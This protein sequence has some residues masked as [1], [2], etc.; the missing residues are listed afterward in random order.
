MKKELSPMEKTLAFSALK[1]R[2]FIMAQ[3]GAIMILLTT[4]APFYAAHAIPAIIIT[5]I[6]IL[7]DKWGGAQIIHRRIMIITVLVLCF[8]IGVN[9]TMQ[10]FP[11]P[12]EVTEVRFPPVTVTPKI[13]LTMGFVGHVIAL[14]GAVETLSGLKL[15]KD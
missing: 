5:I 9:T 8:W 4:T 3:S 12:P 13:T 14:I 7:F 10:W 15:L 1:N 2:F 11:V 6:S